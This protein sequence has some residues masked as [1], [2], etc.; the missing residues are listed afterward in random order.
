V[1]AGCGRPTGSTGTGAGEPTSIQVKGSDTMVNLTQ[2]WA[3]AYMQT[4]PEASIAVTGGGSGTGIAALLNGTTD[5]A[6][7]S[8][9]IK[10]K[11]ISQGRAKGIEPVESAVALDGI[12]VI[13]NPVNKIAKLDVDQ[14]SAIFTGKTVNWSEVGGTGKKIVALSRDRSSGTHVFFLEHVLRKGNEKGPEEY[15]N[16]VLLLPSSQAIVDEVAQSADAIGYIGLGYLSDKV[17]SVAVA[18]SKEADYVAPSVDNV[19]SKAYPIS[20]SLL[21]Y[22]NGAPQGAIKDFI[23]YVLSPEGQ[24]IV[25]EQGFVPIKQ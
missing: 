13:V 4:H 11:E 10:E 3:E 25:E 20:R 19:R 18:G 16:N 23:D 9:D 14:L 15:G 22:T 1:A 5:I 21:M 24:K 12:A 17:K 8:R 7:A 2:A 6:I